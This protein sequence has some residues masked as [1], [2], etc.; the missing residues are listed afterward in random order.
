MP[1]VHM[2]SSESVVFK[3]WMDEP[4]SQ[5]RMMT[6]KRAINRSQRTRG[7]FVMIC[8]TGDMRAYIYHDTASEYVR[9]ESAHSHV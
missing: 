6:I 1:G 3:S 5:L 4:L 2:H 8:S 7:A 9:V